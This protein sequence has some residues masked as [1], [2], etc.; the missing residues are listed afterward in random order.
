M[1]LNPGR[2]TPPGLW[3]RAKLWRHKRRWARRNIARQANADAL[4]VSHTKSGRTW[5]RIM[6]SYLYYLRYNTPESIILDYDNL[7]SLN[8]A[9]PR[10]YFNRDTRVPTFGRNDGHVRVPADKKVLF[11][12]R[13]PRDV[14]VSFYF[15]VRNRASAHELSRKGIPQEAGSLSLYEFVTHHSF[16]IPRVIEHFNRW[17]EEM[18]E[19]P[20]TLLVHYETMRSEPV[21]TLGRIMRFLDRPF[22]EEELRQAVAFAS[23]D[24]LARKEKE[25]FFDSGR[26]RPTDPNDAGSF[27]VRR[28]KVGGYRDYFT[29][30]ENAVIDTIVR[31]QLNPEFGY[32]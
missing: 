15:H 8:P 30:A 31:E 17:H 6:I 4:I 14:A 27:K 32:D 29:D 16:G 11:L 25:G 13:D 19:M 24:S 21:T 10:L 20:F 12:V 1:G 5:L 7:H 3:Q 18:R 2:I 23:F 22:S 9:I 28:G 26:M